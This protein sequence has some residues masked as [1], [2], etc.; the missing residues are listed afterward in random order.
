MKCD[1]VG[2]ADCGK[3]HAF[4]RF[5]LS[6]LFVVTMLFWSYMLRSI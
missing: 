1:H 3:I 6:R 5:E 4:G 2:I